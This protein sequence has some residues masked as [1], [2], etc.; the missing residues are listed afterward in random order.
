MAPKKRFTQELIIEKAYELFRQQGETALTT[1]RVAKE[2]HAS[3]QPLFSCFA[4]ID[5][6]RQ[7]VFFRAEE[8][9]VNMLKQADCT[10]VPLFAYCKAI[11]TFASNEPMMFPTLFLSRY[12]LSTEDYVNYIN[13]LCSSIADTFHISTDQATTFMHILE[14]TA[15][16]MGASLLHEPATLDLQSASDLLESVYNAQSKALA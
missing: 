11:L 6:I 7:Q 2:I 5:E 14:C 9:F 8:E 12:T 10:E 3:T 16:G 1:R 15:V 13:N 4:N